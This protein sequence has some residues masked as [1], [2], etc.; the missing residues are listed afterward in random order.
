MKRAFITGIGGQDG[1]YMTELLKLKG[2]EVFGLE[3]RTGG[4]DLS[5]P[6]DMKKAVQ[7]SQPDEVYNFAGITD[8]KTAYEKPE[9]T[10]KINYE[11]VGHVLDECVKVNPHVRFLQASSSEIF[12]PQ[13]GALNE[14]SPR[15]WET[16][17]PYAGAKMTADKDF[18]QKFRNE[19]NIFCCS[20]FLCNHESPK[21]H[22]SSVLRKITKNIVDIKNGKLDI[23][24]IG[25]VEMARDFGYAGD[26]VEAMWRMLQCEKPEDFVIATGELHTVKEAIDIAANFLGMPVIWLGS[27][28]QTKAYD[29]AGKKIVEVNP[30]FFRENEKF[31]KRGDA[32][33]A[34]RI[35]DWEP[36]MNFTGLIELMVRAALV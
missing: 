28:L 36:H 30:E 6:A 23:L 15:D 34:R 32:S 21:R 18:I 33:K 29:A 2:Y 25:N 12:I 8:L 35:L 1:F 9:L 4:G 17:N 26:Y 24:Q 13:E 5:N 3:N 7:M 27:G 10:N 20:A 11:C 16:K 19:K 14:E 22:E 31:P